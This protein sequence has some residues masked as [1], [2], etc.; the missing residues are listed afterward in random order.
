MS[1][2][3]PS[4]YVPSETELLRADAAENA[5]EILT[6]SAVCIDTLLE[7]EKCMSNA[8]KQPELVS[9]HALLSV[10]NFEGSRIANALERIADSLDYRNTLS[11]PSKLPTQR[12]SQIIFDALKAEYIKDASQQNQKEQET[13]LTEALIRFTRLSGR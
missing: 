7:Q 3:V 10:L 2:Q 13:A 4:S 8:Q 11:D 5:S 9:S 1:A 12:E 6:D